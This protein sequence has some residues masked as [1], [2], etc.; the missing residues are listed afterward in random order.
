MV[1]GIFIG[2]SCAVTFFLFVANF[3]NFKNNN[4]NIEFNKEA[5]RLL[6]VRV[7]NGERAAC[8]LEKLVAHF[9]SANSGYEA[10]LRVYEE[11]M[12]TPGVNHSSMALGDFIE[13]RLHSEENP[14]QNVS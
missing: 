3:G 2:F 14:P 8:A 7:E 4:R 6:Q 10:A 11:F 1:L 13:Q 12:S 5:N 9:T